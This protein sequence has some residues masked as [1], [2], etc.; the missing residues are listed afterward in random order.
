M[1]RGDA[2]LARR[3]PLQQ[4]SRL[5]AGKAIARSA[6]RKASRPK[7]PPKRVVDL[8]RQRS[9]GMCEIGLLCMG[10]A[11][12]T[13][14]AHRM[15]KGMGGAGSKGRKVS[16]APSDLLDACRRDHDLIDR[17]SVAESYAH[18]YKIRHGVVLPREVPVL[19]FACGWVLLDDQGGGRPA[20]EA[21]WDRKR[22]GHL[23]PVVA[24]GWSW[25]AE[26]RRLYVDEGPVLEAMQR[27]GHLGCG[28]W[29]WSAGGPLECACGA[30]PF[31]VE[32][33]D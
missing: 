19:H 31:V 16:D 11:L 24:V 25:D 8:V 3:T 6:E 7:T 1:P 23:L 4:A 21:A 32:V 15:G 22:T 28:Q 13:E 14:R 5:Q 17:A 29:S 26:D 9:G 10:A 27:F 12:A 2:G 30:V 18:G 20:P 33:V